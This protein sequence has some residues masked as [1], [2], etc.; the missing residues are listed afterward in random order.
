MKILGIDSSGLTASV[1]VVEDGLLVAEYTTCYKKTHSQTLLPMLDK[2]KQEI[3]LDLNTIDAI[4]I[5]A[6]PGSFTGLRIGSATAKGLG[7]ALDKP[8]V[9]VPTMEAMAYGLFGAG[10]VCP[11]MDARRKQAFYGIF[12]LNG[13][14]IRAIH[15]DD[16]DDIYAIIDMVNDIGRPVTYMGDGADAFRDIIL[17]KTMVETYFAPAHLS[18][19][20]AGAVA[21]LGMRYYIEGKCETAAAHRPVYLRVSQAERERR[22]FLD[23]LTIIG[24]AS[25]QERT[26]DEIAELEQE[27]FTREAWKRQAFYDAAGSEHAICLCA[28]DGDTVV[29]YL[30]CYVAADQSELPMI[31][32]APKARHRGVGESLLKRLIELLGLQ[33]VA[34]L[35]LE[36]RES[37]EAAIAM[38]E[39]A[40]FRQT[41]KRK[42]FY[43]EPE[44]DALTHLL[45][46]EEKDD[47]NA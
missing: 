6:G 35:Y 18:R 41:G 33:G 45:Y 26:I 2:L 28:K 7:L 16:V 10:V 39:K 31:A 13:A 14:G 46:I 32:V 42:A 23:R 3:E 24:F 30:V 25:N 20:R 38:Y 44:E 21:A 36:V 1:A 37:N 17:E 27:I 19:Q 11:L 43:Q 5:A 34:T 47:Q 12:E 40:G 9:P 29:G 8:I 15:T 4:A 22:E